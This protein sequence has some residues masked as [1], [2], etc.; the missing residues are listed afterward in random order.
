MIKKWFWLIVTAFMLLMGN[1]SAQGNIP[2][3]YI[4]RVLNNTPGTW[5]NYSYTFT[6]ATT[7]SNYFMLAF[8]QD[9]AY[10]RVDNIKVTA[11]GSSTNLLT[12]GDMSTG[13]GVSVNNGQQYIQAPTAWGVAYQ[14]GTYPSAAGTWTGGLWYDG[15]VGSY[16]AIYQ[17]VR[18]TAGQTYTLSF[19]VNGDHQATTSTAGWQIGVYAGSCGNVGLAPT[20]CTLPSNAGFTQ[21]AKPGETYTAGCTNDCPTNPD[22]GPT[23]T[24]TS[25]SN[26]VTTSN[27]VGSTTTTNNQYTWGGGTY[28]VTGTSTP[29][30]T[31]TTTTPV[32]TTYWSDGTTTT[33]NGSSTTTTSVTYNYTVTKPNNA[34]VNPNAGT[35]T[36]SVYITQ[37]NAGASNKIKANQSGHGNYESI[38]LGG[39]NNN[40]N[41]GQGYTFSTTGVATES[42]T[43]SNSNLIGLSLS[44]NSNTV[45]NSQVGA[46][47]S[48]ILSATGN[49]NVLT[50]TQ[51]GNTN[52][53]YSTISG[54]SNSL[55]IGQTGNSNVAAANLYGNSNTAS[56]SQTGNN[57]GTVLNLINAGGANNVSVIQ[58]GTG[59]AYSLQQTCT[60]PA[61]CSVSVI[62]NK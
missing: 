48:S 32:T 24:G 33:S 34:P 12:N 51:T 58:T 36:N 21:L 41:L 18:L 22:A 29:T 11:P 10:W 43:A 14:N 31:T 55:T 8:R 28:T 38:S 30:T 26:N 40:I 39:S 7:G 44:G 54:N 13:G 42:G 50:I 17:A 46:S 45:S 52:Q 62:R 2:G 6:A 59:D 23:V 20:E 3:G 57:H 60:N 49:S 53:T 5:Q 27:S 47:N 35:N 1:A 9:P 25:T 19:D 37:I 4:G 61:G 16:D 15:A 56:I